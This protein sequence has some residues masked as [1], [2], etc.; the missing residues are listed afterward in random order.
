MG[1]DLKSGVAR[2]MLQA[3]PT[4]GE[5]GVSETSDWKQ[6]YRD[7]VL[8][9]EAEQKRWQQIEKVLRRLINR[10]CA[11]GM[12][13]N[14]TLDTELAEVAAANRRSAEVDELET[15]VST[16]TT[17]VTAV[18]QVAPILPRS[19]NG[20]RWESACAATGLLLDRLA[21]SET[22]IDTK[23][24]AL[25]VELTKARTDAEL[26]AILGHAADLVQA[27]NA[28]A[29]GERQ[30]A[31]TVLSAVNLRLEELLEYFDSS[32][33]AS[34]AGHEDTAQLDARLMTQVRELSDG[35]NQATDLAS[36]QA[37]VTQ[38][39]ESVG[40]S[41]REFRER[42]ERRLL[43]QN[44]Q[45]EEMRRRVASLEGETRALNEKLAAERDRA[46]IDPLTNICNRKAFDERLAQEIARRA[47]TQG[48]VS[49]LVW[50]I[51]DFKTINDTYG[52]RAGDRVLQTVA[53]YL[54][55]G[56]QSTDF[57]ARI[58]GEEFTMVLI[59]PALEAAQQ[60]ADELRETIASLRLHFRGTPVHV[61]IS[62]GITPLLDHDTPGRAFERAD[63][64]LYKAKNGGK[65]SCF[66][67]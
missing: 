54:A 5:S 44:A 61:T 67:G 55:Q 57:V 49:L 46:R 21:Q 51:D 35:S 56:I 23:A 63:A 9:M 25:R 12:G 6:K 43:E 2:P 4:I 27:R 64:A 65:N 66:A 15:L 52:H 28:M 16:L 59:G 40:Q 62:C 32:A 60:I 29:E 50:D 7:T 48:P 17:A 53:K 24:G 10:L 58:G 22:D 20:G 47:I 38:G 45:A 11:A 41:V 19:A 1:S 3:I 30:Q 39:L 33:D 31:A 13:V 14:E 26:A 18:D 42:E 34:R 8:E 36:L 37:L